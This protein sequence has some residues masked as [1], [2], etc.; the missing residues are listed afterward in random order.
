MKPLVGPVP[1]NTNLN[2]RLPVYIQGKGTLK[3]PNITFCEVHLAPDV[4]FITSGRFKANS[5]TFIKDSIPPPDVG[6]NTH[7]GYPTYVVEPGAKLVFTD[8]DAYPT[9]LIRRP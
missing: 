2:R 9:S 7:I 6:W 8:K 3:C 4:T 5:S 1:G